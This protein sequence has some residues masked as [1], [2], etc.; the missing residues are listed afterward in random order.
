MRRELE[1]QFDRAKRN[2]WLPMCERAALAYDLNPALILAIASR[3]TNLNP[4]YLEVPGDG[5]NGFGLTQADKRSYPDFVESGDWKDA[6]KCFQFTA[7]KIF[8]ER[9]SII[10]RQAESCRA[11][12]R[13]G[14]S[15]E[16][17]GA[18]LTDAEALRVAIAG[19]NCGLMTAYYHFSKGRSADTGTTQSNYSED[20]LERAAIFQ[21]LWQAGKKEVVIP[22]VES[23]KIE[24]EQRPEPAVEVESG[25]QSK[26]ERKSAWATLGAA[27]TEAAH[28]VAAW[29]HAID[30]RLW[31]IG[32]LSLVVIV[33]AVLYWRKAR[34]CK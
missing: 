21:G 8:N 4:R 2:G 3:E 27:V 13:N 6:A 19:Y 11:R 18:N 29:F 14:E 7:R 32:G 24:V 34:D 9:D 25:Q 16:F 33:L 28:Q 26:P 1:R 12:F 10:L 20:V 15:R 23:P 31:V 30:W 5:G 17:I 22:E